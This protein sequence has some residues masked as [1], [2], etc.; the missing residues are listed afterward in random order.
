MGRDGRH[1]LLDLM[2]VARIDHGH[3]RHG[4]EQRQ[5]LGRLVA[6][7]VAGGQARQRADDLHVAVLF[8]DRLVDEVVGAARSEHR[9]GRREGHEALG[10]MPGAA[11]N[12]SCS[13]MPIW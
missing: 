5:V 8:R 11:P 1:D 12:S 7:A 9:I 2:R 3:V 4:A 6:R 13:A 10:A